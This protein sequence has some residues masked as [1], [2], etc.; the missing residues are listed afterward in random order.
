MMKWDQVKSFIDNI[1]VFDDW[2]E[3]VVDHPKVF[4][5]DV[6]ND[7]DDAVVVAVV[8]DDDDHV[9]RAVDLNDGFGN[10]VEL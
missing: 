7:D 5:V 8:D 9:K 6:D 3:P 2:F 1:P 10:V 4:V